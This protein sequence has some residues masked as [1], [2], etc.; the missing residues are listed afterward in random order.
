M[1]AMTTKSST[2]EKA[3]FALGR[4]SF[5]S[6]HRAG[7][8]VPP[9]VVQFGERGGEFAAGGFHRQLVAADFAPSLRHNYFF[10]GSSRMKAQDTS[11]VC[12]LS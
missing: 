9:G 7:D 4:R 10:G 2:S 8:A 12:P 6:R 11:A 3:D 5:I 1:M